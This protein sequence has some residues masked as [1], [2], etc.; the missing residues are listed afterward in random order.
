MLIL[1]L[2]L[3]TEWMSAVLLKF[4][5]SVFNSLTILTSTMKMKHGKGL[6]AE[7][8][9]SVIPLLGAFEKWAPADGAK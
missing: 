3:G 2:G 1:L 8:T 9:L 6:R 5:H 4:E 7:S